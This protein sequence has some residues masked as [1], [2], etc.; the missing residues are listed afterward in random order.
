MVFLFATTFP[1]V[2]AQGFRAGSERLQ[3]KAGGKR[4]AVCGDK[5]HVSVPQ[6]LRQI[7]HGR[8]VTCGIGGGRD[9]Y[10][11]TDFSLHPLLSCQLVPIQQRVQGIIHV[12][13]RK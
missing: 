3:P 10:V 1:R 12:T 8:R 7:G 4:V 2:V 9:A 13:N 6:L 11:S 5:P